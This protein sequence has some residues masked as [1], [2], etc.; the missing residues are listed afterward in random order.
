MGLEVALLSVCSFRLDMRL[1]VKA[2]GLAM[3]TPLKGCR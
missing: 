1:M 2:A 3:F